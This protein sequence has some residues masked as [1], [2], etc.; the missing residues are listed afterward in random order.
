[1]PTLTRASVLQASDDWHWIPP[2]AEAL[3]VMGV[4]VIDYPE[5]ARM[6]FRATPTMV[7]RPVE[8]V[9][10][11]V[12]HAAAERGRSEVSWWISPS[13][14]AALEGQLIAAGAVLSEELEIVAYDMPDGVT[15]V[16]IPDEVEC[17]LVA[18]PTTLDDAEQVAALVWGGSPSSGE[19]R[20]QQLQ[21]LGG[22]LDT[23]HGFRVV[24]YLADRAIATA[25]CE[26]AGEV[27]RLYGGGT[28]LEARGQG[29]YRAT[30]SKRLE[31]AWQH[32]ARFGLV[33]ARVGTSMPI[34]KR[35]GF[36][37]YGEARLYT[38]QA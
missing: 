29:G 6:G 22:P 34:L 9:V 7:E 31:I 16:G 26:I 37:S 15:E 11:A 8:T 2:G 21:Q 1:M 20:E 38:L 32:G 27:A 4:R 3:D 14:T 5:W 19:R 30:V 25:G 12:Q 10:D 28:L 36:N 17:R 18:D 35:L 33:Q 23:D 24:A 13:T